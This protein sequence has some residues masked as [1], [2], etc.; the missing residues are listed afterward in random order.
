MAIA[1]INIIDTHITLIPFSFLDPAKLDA[2]K[3]VDGIGLNEALS[4]NLFSYLIT[5]KYLVSMLEQ[6]L[7]TCFECLG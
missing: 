1:L 6:T 3:I 7:D 2:N 4:R 5:Q